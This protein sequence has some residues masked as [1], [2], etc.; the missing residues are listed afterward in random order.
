MQS[1][2]LII[3]E[4]SPEQG[5]ISNNQ[6]WKGRIINL[7]GILFDVEVVQLTEADVEILPRDR[8]I[9]MG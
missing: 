8:T 4:R 1:K 2:N 9:L 3:G 6:K 5:K 7:G